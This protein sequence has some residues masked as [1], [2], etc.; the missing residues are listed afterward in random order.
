[1][2]E[3]VRKKSPRSPSMTLDEALDRAL[4]AY[5]RE[6]LHAAP[7]DVVA[8]NIGYKTA[9]S[10]AALG[11]LASMRYFGLFER[12]KEG[13]L[14]VTKDV[15]SYKFAP[16]ERMRRS[17]L[18]G[19]LRRPQLYSDM[20]EK[21]NTGLPSDANLRFE[22]I[23]QRGFSP[24]AAESTLLAFRRSVEFAEFYSLDHEASQSSSV[25]AVVPEVEDFDGRDGP[26]GKGVQR[27]SDRLAPAAPQLHEAQEIPALDRIPVRLPGG[28]RAWLYIPTPFFSTDKER[29]KAQIDLLLTEEDE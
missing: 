12:P 1:M 14:A 24:Q 10:G 7:I 25:D 11:A 28:R 26:N 6:R 18:I 15:E 2:N 8:Q 16:D 17:L 13:F 22:L 27:S 29:L 4:R 23:N 19:F 3:S 21:Y 5:D 9:S 20:L